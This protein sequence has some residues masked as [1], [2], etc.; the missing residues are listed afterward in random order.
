MQRTAL[1]PVL[2]PLLIVAGALLPITWRVIS[3]PPS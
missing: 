2:G 1:H 3:F